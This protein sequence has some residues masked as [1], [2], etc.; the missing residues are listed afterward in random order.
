MISTNS[1]K[2]NA[3]A[4][5]NT[6][7]ITNQIMNLRSEV[8]YNTRDYAIDFLVAQFRDGEFFINPEYQRQFVWENTR[9]CRFI[10]S[11]LLGYPI[12]FMFFSDNDDGRCDIVD[13]AQRTSTLEEFLNGDLV[14]SDLKKLTELNGFTYNQLPPPIQRKFA[15]TT[16]RI[17]ALE[18]GTSIGVRQ[19]IFRGREKWNQHI[20]HLMNV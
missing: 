6:D 10:E 11:I 12:P 18:E 13:G 19:E 9:K 15:K 4:T 1:E 8:D 20:K 16:L 17:I 7:G 14:L 2:S 3:I 5:T